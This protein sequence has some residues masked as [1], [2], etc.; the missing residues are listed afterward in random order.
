MAKLE[1][2]EGKVI[3]T[4]GPATYTL[5]LNEDEFMVLMLLI[6]GVVGEPGG[7]IRELTGPLWA[8]IF[9]KEFVEKVIERS[10]GGDFAKKYNKYRG[11]F[12]TTTIQKETN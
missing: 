6:G 7:T 9:E 2:K 4:V 3:T 8:S 5:T 12:K 11:T 1:I 10:S